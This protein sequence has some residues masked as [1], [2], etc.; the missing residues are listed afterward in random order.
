[1]SVTVCTEEDKG[2]GCTRSTNAWR[3]HSAAC[4]PHVLGL[5]ISSCLEKE[6]R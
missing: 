4:G 6:S 5:E 2:F 1:M 3:F